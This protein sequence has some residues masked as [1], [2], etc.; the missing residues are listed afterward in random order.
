MG[1]LGSLKAFFHI[2]VGTRITNVYYTHYGDKYELRDGDQALLVNLNALNNDEKKQLRTITREY[3]D[4]GKFLLEAKTK[5]LLE[6]LYD[7]NKRSPNSSILGFFRDIIPP[8]DLEALDASLYLREKFISDRT[9][10][11]QL[12][13]DIVKNFGN[14]GGNIANLCTAGY[15][16]NFLMNLYNS[17]PEQFKRLYELIVPK[18]IIAVFVYHDMRKEDIKREID[19]KIRLCKRYGIPFMH[20]HGIGKDNTKKIKE[21]LAEESEYFSY[22][23]KRIFEDEGKGILAVELLLSNQPPTDLGKENDDP[24]D[25][26]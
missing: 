19:L 3:L 4:T 24:T 21:I 13:Y 14:R 5:S 23:Q 7:Y 15:F 20:I 16:E 22:Y 18:S 2:E 8:A 12:K 1:W 6:D 26:G 17:S 9:S 25:P 10:V 11:P